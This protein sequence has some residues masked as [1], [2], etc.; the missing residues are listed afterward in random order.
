[1]KIKKNHIYNILFVILLG[2]IVYP[3]SR[4][5]FMRQL[6]FS[7]SVESVNDREMLSDYTWQLKGLTANDLD[8]SSTKGKVIFVNF[9]ATWCPPCR[10]EM[11]MI[12]KLYDDYKD[13]VEFVMVTTDT[14]KKV[15]SYYKKNDYNLPTYGM[16]SREPQQMVTTSIPA[17]YLID[18]KGNIVISKVGAADWNSAK[19]RKLIDELL[20]Q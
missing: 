3:N 13:K 9:W 19:V 20:S 14:K 17:S 18:K 8:F 11:P 10:A 16:L 15:E 7:P 5:W 2:L 1:M 6:A 4:T 12:Q